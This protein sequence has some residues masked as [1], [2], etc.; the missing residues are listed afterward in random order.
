MLTVMIVG[1]AS[2]NNFANQEN[3]YEESMEESEC[4]AETGM[5]CEESAQEWADE[6][7]EPEDSEDSED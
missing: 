1:V 4:Y 5:N 6:N 7:P 2:A 3:P